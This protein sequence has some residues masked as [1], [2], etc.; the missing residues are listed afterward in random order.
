ML[1][2][3]GFYIYKIQDQVALIFDVGSQNSGYLWG[4]GEEG[5]FN[6]KC[7]DKLPGNAMGVVTWMH[8]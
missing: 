4:E 1:Y 6:W 7:Q 8:K 5:S 2:T 3:P